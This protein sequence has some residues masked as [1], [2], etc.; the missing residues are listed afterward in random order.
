M[1]PFLEGLPERS[2]FGQDEDPRFGFFICGSCG[3]AQE[4]SAEPERFWPTDLGPL[5]V[6]TMEADSV[7]RCTGLLSE[8]A[9][10]ILLVKGIKYPG[11]TNGAETHAAGFVQCLTGVPSVGGSN[12]ATSTGPSADWVIARAF[13]GT[14]L[15]LYAGAKGG[16][17][18]DR[19]SFREAGQL[20][21]AEGD[22]YQTY[23][24]LTGLAGAGGG[25]SA[26]ANH[27]VLRRKSVN[28]LV[29]DDLQTLLAEKALS[30]ADRRRLDLHLSSLREV[31]M[32]MPTAS[33]SVSGL[34]QELIESIGPRGYIE[35]VARLQMQLTGIAFSCNLARAA[36]LQWGGGTDQT[37]YVVDG[38]T[39][40]R[41]HH[42]SHRIN[43][44][45]TTGSPIENAAEKHAA[46]DRIRM[47]TLT[48]MLDHWSELSTPKGPLFQSA[49]AMWTCDVAVG[50]SGSFL[51][52]P[53]IIAGSPGGSL[54]QAQY[55]DAER[56]SNA[57]LLTSLIES[58][59]ADASQFADQAGGLS[60]IES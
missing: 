10:K 32:Q 39:L 11:G 55:V 50:P 6:Q 1:L 52:L 56:V 49:F 21:Y 5:S 58:T 27:L 19:L 8:H 51:N 15:N 9:D 48:T 43:G 42:I 3:V 54:K 2:A 22:P 40:E 12:V 14:P 17:I 7:E 34:D 46:I 35:D 33:C 59:G 30:A 29:R 25:P 16:Y 18:D 20:V 28:D 31:E 23:L 36:T 41:F 13:S 24:T 37:Q 57:R 60:V 38:V 53:I 44:D 47:Q 26:M 45:G 4:Y